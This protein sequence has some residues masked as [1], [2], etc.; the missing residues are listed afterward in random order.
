[1]LPELKEPFEKTGGEVWDMPDWLE[2]FQG[3][4]RELEPN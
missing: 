1:V 4:G 3:G 2:A